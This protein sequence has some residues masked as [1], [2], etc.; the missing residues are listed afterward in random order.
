MSFFSIFQLFLQSDTFDFT[1]CAFR[2][3]HQEVLLVPNP[4]YLAQWRIIYFNPLLRMEYENMP[5]PVSR[6][7]KFKKNILLSTCMTLLAGRS[8]INSYAGH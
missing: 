3:R 6:L 4:S 1:K 8:L 2:T 7:F 5:V